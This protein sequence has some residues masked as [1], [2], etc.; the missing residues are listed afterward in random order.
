[1]LMKIL[2][3]YK[4]TNTVG[5]PV[6]KIKEAYLDLDKWEVVAFEVSPGALK[7][8]VLVDLKEMN[9]LDIEGKNLIVKDDH[10]VREVPKTPRK[11]LYPLKELMDLHVID[12]EGEKVGK[13]Y[14]L[15]IPYEK[16]H[17]FK[18][19]KM[20]IRTGIKERR[21][22]LSPSEVKDVM[23]DIRLKKAEK[24]YVEHAE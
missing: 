16:L 1:M 8:H 7:K 4:V 2:E 10:T 17:R 19:W 9:S 21:L 12:A 24:E 14:D 13:V 6:G 23:A 5:E 18:V 20:L 22:R 3:E 15:E 11:D